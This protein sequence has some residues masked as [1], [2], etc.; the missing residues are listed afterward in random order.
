MTAMV[1]H[2]YKQLVFCT[3]QTIEYV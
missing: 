2:A 1:W 3:A